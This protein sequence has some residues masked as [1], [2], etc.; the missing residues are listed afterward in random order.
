MIRRPPRST[1]FPYTTLFRSFVFGHLGDGNLHLAMQVPPERYPEVKPKVE[2]EVYALLEEVGGSVSA[3]HGIGL[4]KKRWL[5][6]SRS[7]TEL[8]LMRSLKRLLDPKNILNPGKIVDL[9]AT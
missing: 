4:D 8:A 9:G 5:H 3:E 7:E 2:A 1:L 6:V